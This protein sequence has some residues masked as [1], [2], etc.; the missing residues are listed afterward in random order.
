MKSNSHQDF[1]LITNVNERF[2]A[3]LE[4]K[5]DWENDSRSIFVGTVYDKE[6]LKKIRENAY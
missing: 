4:D 5:L 2:L 3:K 6:L 1:S